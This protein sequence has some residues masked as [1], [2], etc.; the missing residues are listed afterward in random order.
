M[1]EKHWWN[2][3]NRISEENLP[4]YKLVQY[5]TMSTTLRLNTDLCGK[6]A[7]MCLSYGMASL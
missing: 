6:R 2:K 3:N 5:K 1:M 4:Q 7:L